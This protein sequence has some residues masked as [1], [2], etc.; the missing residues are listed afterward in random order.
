ME[1]NLYYFGQQTSG[2]SLADASRHLYRKELIYVGEFKKP[3]PN[4]T[5]QDFSVT[6]ERLKHWKESSGSHCIT[7]QKTR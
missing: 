1:T 2:L 4:G 7:G 3:L 6:P 5:T